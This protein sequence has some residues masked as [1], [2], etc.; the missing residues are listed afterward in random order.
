MQQWSPD[1]LFLITFFASAFTSIGHD[2]V[3]GKSVTF[4]IL[5][6]SFLFYGGL[7]SAMG[8]LAYSW[9]GG[10]QAPERV[11][12][13]GIFVGARAIKVKD[14]GEYLRRVIG[15]IAPTNQED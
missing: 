14:A 1:K 12:I 4:K 11:L 13:C 15:G 5:V 9:L 8:M 7:G 2:L 10:K 6:G 3:F